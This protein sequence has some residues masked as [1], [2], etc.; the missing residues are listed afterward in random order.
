MFTG[1]D[2]K[3]NKKKNPYKM[4]KK[5]EKNHRKQKNKETCRQV[6]SIRDKFA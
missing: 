3:F 6:N 4:N 5:N 2:R 1:I